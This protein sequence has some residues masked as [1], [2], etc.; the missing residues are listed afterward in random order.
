[1]IKQNSTFTCKY[2]NYKYLEDG[3]VKI[4]RLPMVNVI[5]RHNEVALKTPGLVDSGST[6]TFLPLELSVTLGLAKKS[7][8]KAI[9]AGGEFETSICE[10]DEIMIAKGET[11]FL[12]LYHRNIIVPN[13]VER[14]PY[15]VLGRDTIFKEND[16][17]FFENR[18]KIRF[19]S[20]KKA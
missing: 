4:V 1:M 10:I 7:E 17:T 12:K 6:D 20:N 3:K 5:L 11:T 14:V 2:L 15:L 9:G 16:I 13:K 8:S 18:K 19:S